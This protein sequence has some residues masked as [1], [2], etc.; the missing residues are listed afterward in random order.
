MSEREPTETEVLQMLADGWHGGSGGSVWAHFDKGQLSRSFGNGVIRNL[1]RKGMIQADDDFAFSVS[2]TPKGIKALMQ[3]GRVV[4]K[5]TPIKRVSDKRAGQLIEYHAL[6]KKLRG[7]CDN[8]SEL[9]GKEPNWRRIAEPH[10][11]D[12]RENERLLNPFG[13][14]MLLR[15]EHEIEQQHLPGCHTKEYLLALV[16]GIRIK[17]GFKDG[18]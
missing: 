18:R 1:F 4:M 10:H 6:I 12:H 16:H 17:Q 3:P 13:I 11:I 8:K 2:L 14:I 15:R 9:S 7:L 5:Q